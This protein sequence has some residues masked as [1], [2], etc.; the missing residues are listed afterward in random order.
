[1]DQTDEDIYGLM[2]WPQLQ[3]WLDILDTR[4][5]RRQAREHTNPPTHTHPRSSRQVCIVHPSLPTQS[6]SHTTYSPVGADVHAHDAN[7]S[8]RR[9]AREHTTLTRRACAGR[10]GNGQG[11]RAR[12]M[13]K[14]GNYITTTTILSYLLRLGGKVTPSRPPRPGPSQRGSPTC[15]SRCECVFDTPPLFR[16]SIRPRR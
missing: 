9:Q 8:W 1:M 6:G 2:Y 4:S 11:Q 14:R 12:A 7:R 3:Q 13:G 10:E 5:W 15:A 16:T